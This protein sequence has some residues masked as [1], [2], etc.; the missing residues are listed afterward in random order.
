[1]VSSLSLSSSLSPTYS[2][3]VLPF[4]NSDWLPSLHTALSGSNRKRGDKAIDIYQKLNTTY[5][6][7]K[8]EIQLVEVSIFV[9]IFREM[10]F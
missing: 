6:R 7:E 2:F 3:S 5:Y 10:V 4:F 1:M 9:G 8:K